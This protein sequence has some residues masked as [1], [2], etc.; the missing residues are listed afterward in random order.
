MR[1]IKRKGKRSLPISM[2]GRYVDVARMKVVKN[3]QGK[4]L[5]NESEKSVFEF[6]KTSGCS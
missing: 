4:S 6:E 3:G 2:A 5:Y 1:K